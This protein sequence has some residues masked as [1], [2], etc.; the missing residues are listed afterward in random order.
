M[1]QS[2]ALLPFVPDQFSVSLAV[3]TM[4]LSNK[5]SAH[6]IY[7]F[8]KTDE[9]G[10]SEYLMDLDFTVYLYSSDVELE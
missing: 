2:A 5:L 3:N 9:L 10:F 7:D 6:Y 4:W 1:A 8:P